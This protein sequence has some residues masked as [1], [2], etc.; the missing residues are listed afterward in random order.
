[1]SLYISKEFG[2]D[3]NATVYE[4]AEEDLSVPLSVS[5]KVM[6]WEVKG[7]FFFTVFFLKLQQALSVFDADEPVDD[8]KVDV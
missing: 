7:F 1:L 3:K 5:L 2:V 8:G 6:T 4:D